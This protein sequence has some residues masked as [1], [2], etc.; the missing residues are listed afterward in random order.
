MGFLREVSCAMHYVKTQDGSGY[1]AGG[2]MAWS[3]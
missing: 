2:L 1:R 3:R